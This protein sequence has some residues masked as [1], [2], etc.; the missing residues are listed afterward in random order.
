MK[1]FRRNLKLAKKA[2]KGFTLIELAIVGLFLGLLAIFAISQFTGGATDTTRANGMAESSQ[3]IADNWSIVAQQCQVSTDVTS[4][5][6]TTNAATGAAAGNLS[7]LLGNTA[8]HSTY[9]SCFNQSGV[10]PLSNMAVGSA[11][12]ETIYSYAVTLGN[13][14][15][16][17]KNAMTVSYAGVPE[18]IVLALYN[19]L[20][21]DAN[22]S[23]ATVVPATANTSD[24]ALRF[25]AAVSG[26]RTVTLV[27]TL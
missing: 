13:T 15:I 17:G 6:L 10:K 16:N 3:K 4:L 1:L 27:R 23:T 5:N 7:M 24:P 21:S 2:Q 9:T 19:R 26:R 11:G 25:S 20:S 18:N 8:P 22:A 12:N 14:S